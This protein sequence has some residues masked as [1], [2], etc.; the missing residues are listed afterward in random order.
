MGL[1]ISASKAY[2]HLMIKLSKLPNESSSDPLHKLYSLDLKIS[3]E[4]VEKIVGSSIDGINCV[5]ENLRS[6]FLFENV[7]DSI[8][9]AGIL[10]AVSFIGC[11]CNLLTCLILSWICVFTLPR[12]YIEKK[13]V[14]DGLVVKLQV[15]MDLL[16]NKVANMSKKEIVVPAAEKNT[17]EKEE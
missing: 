5:L 12:L 3:D 8:K 10:Y 11:V 7:V 17:P 14:V 16:K 6:L 1:V 9:F 4:N 15:Q 13:D 2:T